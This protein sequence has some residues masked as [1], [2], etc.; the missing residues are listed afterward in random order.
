MNLD[1]QRHSE[2][3]DLID[4]VCE[5]QPAPEIVDRLESLLLADDDACRYCLGYLSLHGALILS[6]RAD[7]ERKTDGGIGGAS[8][9]GRKGSSSCR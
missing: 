1:P 6:V 2:L 3:S 7:G 8:C 4:A 9:G 5:N